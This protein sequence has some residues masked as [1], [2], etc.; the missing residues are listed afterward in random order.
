MIKEKPLV[1]CKIEERYYL[2]NITIFIKKKNY[3][4]FNDLYASLHGFPI[5]I[6]I[7]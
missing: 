1:I 2:Y 3:L 7:I 4:F 6:F 5:S